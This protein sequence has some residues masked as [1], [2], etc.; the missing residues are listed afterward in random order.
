MQL[1]DESPT[2][3]STF[4]VTE[5]RKPFSR[6]GFGNKFRQWCDEAELKHCTAHDLRKAGAVIAAENGAT[7]HQLK[8]IFGWTTLKQPELYTRAAEQKRLAADAMPLLLV[9]KGSK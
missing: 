7:A 8:A 4:L 5:F 6:A 9:R 1:R 2:G 3:P